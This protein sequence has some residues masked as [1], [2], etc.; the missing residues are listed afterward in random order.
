MVETL[1][2]TPENTLFTQKVFVLDH[3]LEYQKIVGILSVLDA[4]LLE[5]K[6]PY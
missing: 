5:V 1:Y 2:G 4:S 6:F 3:F